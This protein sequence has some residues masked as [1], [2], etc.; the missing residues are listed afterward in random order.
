[1]SLQP[2]FLQ[3]QVDC[4]C[5]LYNCKCVA[6]EI[7][8]LQTGSLSFFSV[9]SGLQ[10]RFVK[11]ELGCNCDMYVELQ[12]GCNSDLSTCKLVKIEII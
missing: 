2:S 7:V 1:M 11:L 9:I 5:D 12:V 8:K 10:L 4:N 3:L 6:A